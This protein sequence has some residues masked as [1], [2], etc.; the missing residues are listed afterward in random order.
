MLPLLQVR[1][2]WTTQEKTHNQDPWL[3]LG[4]VGPCP[5]GL[6]LI[7]LLQSEPSVKVKEG[8]QHFI[9]ELRTQGALE[10]PWKTSREVLCVPW[11]H[12]A[13]RWN[14]LPGQDWLVVL[15]NPNLTR[16][17]IVTE[18]YLGQVHLWTAPAQI[19]RLLKHYWILGTRARS[20]H[21]IGTTLPHYPNWHIN[22]WMA[23]YLFIGRFGDSWVPVLGTSIINGDAFLRLKQESLFN[24]QFKMLLKESAFFL[25]E[26]IKTLG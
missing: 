18:V 15:R 19:D 20:Q 1:R 24:I 22:I 4:L 25:E 8:L 2:V 9:T 17:C 5:G 12:Q 7:F 26:K 23:F 6:Q 16:P 3:V 11:D 10:H 21:T 13:T 14:R